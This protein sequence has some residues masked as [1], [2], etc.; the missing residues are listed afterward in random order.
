MPVETFETQEDVP[1]EFRE[2]AIETKAGKFIVVREDDTSGLKSALDK[3]R[4][5]R[6]DAE[7]EAKERAQR[8][9]DLELE[10]KASKE[11]LTS[12]RLAEIRKQVAAEFE[13]YRTKAETLEA[14]NRSLKLTDR[15]KA[16]M[17]KADFH[18][19]EAVWKLHGEDF[20]L[21]DDG[22]PIVKAEPGKSLEKH[23]AEIATAKPYL[24]RGTQAAGGDAKGARGAAP[25]KGGKVSA[26]K[27]E[28][29]EAYIERHGYDEFRR[30]L[31]AEMVAAL[32]AT[33]QKQAA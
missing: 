19:V 9:A 32:T 10:A 8:L 5:A 24:V 25:E 11:G 3:E 1:E 2:S 7:K 17:E 21:T 26:L 4:K 27:G 23:I 12:E 33:K 31:D 20:D 30:Q 29:L 6:K 18:D 15:V 14:E 13:P 28:A 16:L 22:Q